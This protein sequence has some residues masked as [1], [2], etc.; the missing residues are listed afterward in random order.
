[1]VL[2]L[3]KSPLRLAGAVLLAAASLW[4]IRTPQPDVLVAPDG[5]SVAIR[6]AAGRL[7]ILRAGNDSFAIQQWLAADAD[8]RTAKDQSLGEGLACDDAGCVGRLTDGSIVAIART[9]EAFAEDCRRAVLVVSSREAP[10]ACAA[11][12]I[13]RRVS[14]RN[15]ALALRRIGAAWETTVARPDGYDRPWARARPVADEAAGAARTTPARAPARD[16]TPRAEDLEL[17][18]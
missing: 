8:P 10:P 9:I 15:G 13:D 5:S 6:T 11:L 2:G 3:L 7:S 17:G 18:D 1:V 12:A 4:A 16:A 14:Q